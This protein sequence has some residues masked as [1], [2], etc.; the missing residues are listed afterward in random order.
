MEPKYSSGVIYDLLKSA[1]LLA[2]QRFEDEL[3]TFDSTAYAPLQQRLDLAKNLGT[4]RLGVGRQSGSTT[5]AIK[6]ANKFFNNK[7]VYLGPRPK[8]YEALGA[9]N[10]SHWIYAS[11]QNPTDVKA[12]F[13]DPGPHAGMQ[14]QK[15]IY[16]LAAE[17]MVTP[18]GLT[19]VFVYFV[20]C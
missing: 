19:P 12:I 1:T 7:A 11:S 2:R 14:A 4:I 5:A 13:V 20:G 18:G 17:A 10:T 9:P 3:A 15:A 16:T 8:D 6:L